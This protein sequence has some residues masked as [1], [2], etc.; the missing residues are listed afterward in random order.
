MRS[1]DSAVTVLGSEIPRVFALAD[2]PIGAEGGTLRLP[3]AMTGKWFKQAATGSQEITMSLSDLRDMVRNFAKRE[4]GEINV[5]YDHKSETGADIAEPIP[6]A[7]RVT[8]LD[9]P[10]EFTDTQ[11]VKH[12]IVWGRYEP[13]ERARQ[14][15]AA[16]E[17]RFTSPA[18][19]QGIDKTTGKP[20]GITLSTVALT[21]RPVITS[22]PKICMSQDGQEANIS[23]LRSGGFMENQVAFCS[24][25]SYADTR[26]S[27]LIRARMQEHGE[28]ASAT[29]MQVVQTAEGKALW[30]AARKASL[31]RG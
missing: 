10:E 22:M 28:S 30:E 13:T 25:G 1:A 12:Y 3:I 31:K 11:G 26:L 29:E 20:Q 5:D 4:N 23:N 24:E 6:S 2:F 14:L 15:I 18:F 21:N 16:K 8:A 9:F 17:Y 7:G 19:G 27:E